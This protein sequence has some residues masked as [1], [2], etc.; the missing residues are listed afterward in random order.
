MDLR[1]WNPFEEL[2]TWQNRIGRL[3]DD[4][5]GAADQAQ[6]SFNNGIL[7]VERP[8]KDRPQPKRLAIG[9]VPANAKNQA[10]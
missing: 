1:R 4:G 8:L 9:S 2:L 5:F 6:T 3:A 7:R 10:S